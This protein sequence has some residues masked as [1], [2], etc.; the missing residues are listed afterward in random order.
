VGEA[1]ALVADVVWNVAKDDPRRVVI[2]KMTIVCEDRPGG[3][4]IFDLEAKGSEQKMKETPFTL[5]ESSKYK[6]KITFKVQHEIVSGLKLVNIVKKKGI[7][8]AT[9]TEMLGSFPPQKDYHEIV[10]PRHGWETAPSGLIA[11][12]KYTGKHR[13]VDDDGQCHL[14]YDYAF[15]IAKTWE[16][17]D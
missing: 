9:E 12:G 7:K 6:T 15:Q 1:D 14:E 17:K 4:I 10:F 2:K 16:H 11:R 13:F 5:Q 3:D 8:V